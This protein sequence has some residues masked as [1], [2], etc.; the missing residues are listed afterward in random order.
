MGPFFVLFLSAL[1]ACGIV[2]AVWRRQERRAFIT[3][4]T[5]VAPLEVLT[6][7]WERSVIVGENHADREALPRIEALLVAAHARGYRTLGVEVSTE[8]RGAYS[9]LADERQTIALV[10]EFELSE[11]D[12]RSSLGPDAS[13][14]RPR[15]NRYWYMH[16]ALRLGWRIVPIDP[17]HWNWTLQT[18]KGYLSS[19][20][21]A[22]AKRIRE[23][24]PM[25]AV[26][27]YGHL[28]GLSKL[29]G[30]DATYVLASE[31]KSADGDDD[32]FWEKPIAFAATLPRLSL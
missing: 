13:G 29:L 32:P 3:P 21:P 18:E 15:V 12:D 5:L 10:A 26:C 17:H 9:G 25:I 7:A 30:N 28:A 16:V 8:G 23:R 24:S 31:V 6:T 20:E 19:R 2:F 4:Q 27:G 1:F 11:H 14:K 22:M